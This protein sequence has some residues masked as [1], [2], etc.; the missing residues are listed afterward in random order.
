MGSNTGTSSPALNRIFNTLPVVPAGISKAALSVSTS[1]IVVSSVTWSPS[2]T[3]QFT[4]IH[5][6]TVLPCLGIIKICAIVIVIY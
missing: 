3:F 2:F 5:D 4:I 6:S 1:Q